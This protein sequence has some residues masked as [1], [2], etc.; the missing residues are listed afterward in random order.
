MIRS[1][2]RN[3][4]LYE[5]LITALAA[6]GF[7]I[8]LGSIF[9]FT[10]GLLQRTNAFFTDLTTIPYSFGGPGS[11]ISLLAPGAPGD[12]I[13]FFTAVMNFLLAI[14]VLQI[15]ILALRLWAKSSIKRM[16]ETVGNLIFWLGAAV[17]ANIFLLSG[18]TNGWYKFWAT[19]IILI[20]ASLI[21]QFF[22]YFAQKYSARMKGH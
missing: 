6:G 4:S 20:G 7:F 13:V 15:V 5:S 22:V 2:V 9:A 16:A 14:G 21:A 18:T 17:M 1:A 3:R 12:H 11:T 10:P 8:I 19:L